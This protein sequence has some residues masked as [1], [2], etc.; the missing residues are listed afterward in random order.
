MPPTIG[1]GLYNMTPVP[2]HNLQH[3]QYYFI[4]LALRAIATEQP[5][6]KTPGACACQHPAAVGGLEAVEG[7]ACKQ[8][9]RAAAYSQ[10][11]D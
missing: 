2:T 5:Q 8:Q 10:S 1:V 7:G 3:P 11:E 6:C 9:S 4:Q